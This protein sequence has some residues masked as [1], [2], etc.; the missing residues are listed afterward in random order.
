MGQERNRGAKGDC[1]VF[2]LSNWQDRL[3]CH[4]RRME[5]LWVEQSYDRVRDGD[6]EFFS[7]TRAFRGKWESPGETSEHSQVG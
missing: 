6:R 1:R 5:R 3:H 7:P 2:C 4:K